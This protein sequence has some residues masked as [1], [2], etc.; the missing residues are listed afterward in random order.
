[1]K[2][3]KLL[4]TSIV[5]FSCLSNIYAQDGPS[6]LDQTGIVHLLRKAFCEPGQQADL[7]SCGQ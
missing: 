6:T 5:L 2:K 4:F 3:I 7:K 1:M